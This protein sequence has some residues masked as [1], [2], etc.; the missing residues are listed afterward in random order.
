MRTSRPL[1]SRDQEAKRPRLGPVRDSDTKALVH[2]KTKTYDLVFRGALSLLMMA[3]L[4]LA[5]TLMVQP[6]AAQAQGLR[7]PHALLIA[8]QDYDDLPTVP[9]ALRQGRDLAFELRAWAISSLPLK[10]PHNAWFST[11]VTP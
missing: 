6:R 9:G 8:N 4:T 2:A 11:A 3:L 10:K 1:S 7:I 5:I